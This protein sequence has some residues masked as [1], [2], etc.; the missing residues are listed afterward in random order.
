VAVPLAGDV[1]VELDVQVARLHHAHVDE[2]ILHL[3]ELRVVGRVHVPT[4]GVGVALGHGVALEL[5]EW[6][7]ALCALRSHKKPRC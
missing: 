5:V 1:L 3:A 6:V 2:E 4:A 7:D